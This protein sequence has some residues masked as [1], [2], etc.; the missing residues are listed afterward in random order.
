MVPKVKKEAPAL[1]KAKNK[2]KAFK[3]KKVMLKGI[4]IYKKKIRMSL[5]FL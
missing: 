2:A 5:T 4:H 1:P 3:A